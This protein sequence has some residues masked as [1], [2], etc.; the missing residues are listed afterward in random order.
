MERQEEERGRRGSEPHRDRH[1]GRKVHTTITTTTMV[2]GMS[3]VWFLLKCTLVA[4]QHVTYS[5][6]SG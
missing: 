4:V 1:R 6:L 5:F 3:F 2:H